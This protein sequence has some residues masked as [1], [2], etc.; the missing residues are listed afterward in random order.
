MSYVYD[1]LQ[2][3]SSHA[4]QLLP[5]VHIINDV[6]HFLFLEKQELIIEDII[7]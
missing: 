4:T 6:C 7:Y 2:I 3:L 5:E 1:K